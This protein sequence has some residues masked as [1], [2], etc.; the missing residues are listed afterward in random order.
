LE[1]KIV[2]CYRNSP[3]DF[4]STNFLSTNFLSTDFS[5]TLKNRPVHPPTFCR[6]ARFI[7]RRFV[8]GRFVERLL[9]NLTK[10]I[11]RSQAAGIRAFDEPGVR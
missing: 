1:H 10:K 9:S 5:S 3:T 2:G 11:I 6:P 7:D 4:L 8:Q